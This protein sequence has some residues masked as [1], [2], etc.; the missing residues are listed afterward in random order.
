MFIYCTDAKIRDEFIK[1]G[2][3]LFKEFD[4]NGDIIFILTDTLN[5]KFSFENIPKNKFYKTNRLPFWNK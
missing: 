4:S 3:K 5:E 2:A 1:N